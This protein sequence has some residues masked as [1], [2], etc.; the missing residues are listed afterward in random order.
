MK[1]ARTDLTPPGTTAPA[2]VEAAVAAVAVGKAAV[3]AEAAVVAV[4][5]P[6]PLTTPLT[7]TATTW[8]TSRRTIKI[9]PINGRVEPNRCASDYSEIR[10]VRNVRH[11]IRGFFLPSGG[12]VQSHYPHPFDVVG[13]TRYL[14]VQSNLSGKPAQELEFVYNVAS[15]VKH[16]HNRVLSR[17]E[18]T[19]KNGSTPSAFDVNTRVALHKLFALVSA[20]Y[21][22][23]TLATHDT[24]ASETLCTLVF[25][26]RARKLL[27]F[28]LV[29][30]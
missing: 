4:A 8:T 1:G 28:S 13:A 15:W 23:V 2:T 10:R 25:R 11:V 27:L 24:A 29:C 5:A 22:V 26:A 19:E 14:K 18:A 12:D 7:A 9:A 17:E 16:L 20:R 3:V 30:L 21:K 6:T